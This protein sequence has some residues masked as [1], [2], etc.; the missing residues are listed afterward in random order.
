MK[1][2]III[3][4]FTK[5]QTNDI[6]VMNKEDYEIA[7]SN[8]LCRGNVYF[9]NGMGV[10]FKGCHTKE[11]KPNENKTSLVFVGEISKRKNASAR[12]SVQRRPPK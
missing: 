12:H 1:A 2:D 4:V 8:K 11:E 7:T 5:N 9:S 10:D 6:I 3:N